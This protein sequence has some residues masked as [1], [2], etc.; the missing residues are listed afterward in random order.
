MI[1]MCDDFFIGVAKYFSNIKTPI[2]PQYQLRKRG[3]RLQEAVRDG[4]ITLT[5]AAAGAAGAVP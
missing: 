1:Y 3:E 4:L 2:P 5:A